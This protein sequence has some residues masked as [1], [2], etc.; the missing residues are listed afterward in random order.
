M[1]D[2][3]GGG[4]GGCVTAVWR[5]RNLTVEIKTSNEAAEAASVAVVSDGRHDRMEL[6]T[7]ADCRKFSARFRRETQNIFC[8][9]S[10]QWHANNMMHAAH[11]YDH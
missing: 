8:G 9:K 1:S 3:R 5:Q 10:K 11:I 4:G 2:L 6:K 7:T